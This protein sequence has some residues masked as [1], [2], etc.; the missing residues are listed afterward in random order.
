MYHR[1]YSLWSPVI[2]VPQ[3]RCHAASRLSSP[4]PTAVRGL[5]FFSDREK[6]SCLSPLVDSRRSLFSESSL[7]MSQ[8]RFGTASMSY[9]SPVTPA[10]FGT[11]AIPVHPTLRQ[12]RYDVSTD[13]RLFGEFGTISV[14]VSDASVS[15]VGP[16][17]RLPDIFG[18]FG[19]PTKKY[20]GLPNTCLQKSGRK[21]LDSQILM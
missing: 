15:T 1:S 7:P 3:I 10:R 2:V 21:N 14:P 4:L 20:P 19:T 11:K 9:R 13:T 6:A 16:Q 18:A 8:A 12:V 17:H 5:T